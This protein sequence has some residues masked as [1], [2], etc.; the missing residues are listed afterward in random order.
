MSSIIIIV[1]FTKQDDHIKEDEMDEAY[2]TCG[3]KR[4][5][6]TIFGQK[7]TQMGRY[8]LNVFLGNRVGACDW[9]HV[10]K[11]RDKWQALVN[12]ARNLQVQ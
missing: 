4:Q 7:A 2:G 1:L 8:Y 11:H 12:T 6:H 9:I 3:G 10:A 5:M